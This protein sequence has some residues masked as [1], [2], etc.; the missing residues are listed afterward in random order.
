LSKFAI[1]FLLLAGSSVFLAQSAPSAIGGNRELW[2]GAEFSD[3]NPDYGCSTNVPLACGN[4]LLGFGV[5]AGYPLR[6]KLGAAGEARWLPWNGV[7]GESESSYLIG[8]SY[9]LW[10]SRTFS[11]SG[12]FLAGVGH[13]SVPQQVSGTYFAYA[14]GA[15]VAYRYSPRVSLF[16]SYEFQSWPLFAGPPTISSSGQV[17]LHN[18]GLSPNGFS[19]GA[20]YRI[21]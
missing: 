19:F 10:S 13:L 16:V 2:V 4:D 5:V 17:I 21:F 14:P 7:V 12:K 20:E 6:G 11:V 15:E 18:H 3:F 9:R 8:P 1:V